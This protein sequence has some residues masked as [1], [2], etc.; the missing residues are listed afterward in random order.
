[1]QSLVR[2]LGLERMLHL[3]R[4][5]PKYWHDQPVWGGYLSFA[6][7]PSGV[8]MHVALLLGFPVDTCRNILLLFPIGRFQSHG[9]A[10]SFATFEASSRATLLREDLYL[11]SM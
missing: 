3:V 10:L 5:D 6:A 11:W 4:G 1:M 7:R 9:L 2:W 8:R